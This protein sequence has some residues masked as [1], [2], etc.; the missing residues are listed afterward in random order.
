MDTLP[1]NTTVNQH[2][3]HNTI[4]NLKFGVY[5]LIVWFQTQLNQQIKQNT[6]YTTRTPT[7]QNTTYKKKKNKDNN[8]NQPLQQQL[9]QERKWIYNLKVEHWEKDHDI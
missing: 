7:K 1:Q 8:K 9:I 3:T 6:T 2:Q 4:Q 5:L